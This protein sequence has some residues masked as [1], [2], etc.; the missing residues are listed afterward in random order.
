MALKRWL[1]KDV[2]PNWIAKA[3]SCGWA[4]I[5]ST[6]IIPN[7]MFTLEVVGRQSGKTIGFPLAMQVMNGERHRVSMLGKN[8]DWVR[9]LKAMDGK[10]IWGMVFV[11]R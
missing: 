2:H 4:I 8:A 3:L 5:H 11:N 6:G 7:Y 9:N 1:Y 10:Q